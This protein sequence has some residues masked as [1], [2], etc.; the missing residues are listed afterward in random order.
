MKD[1]IEQVLESIRPN[2]ARHRGNV[3]L[4]GVDEESGVVQVRFLGTCDGC[5]L[6]TMTLKMGIEAVLFEQVPGV[7]E[8]VAVK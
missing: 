4:V 3:E 5:P 6:A 7:T 8:V 2:L 1:A